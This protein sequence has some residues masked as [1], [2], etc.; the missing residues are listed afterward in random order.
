MW[1]SSEWPPPVL[2]CMSSSGARRG[3]RGTLA[4]TR[5]RRHNTTRG[6]TPHEHVTPQHVTQSVRAFLQHTNNAARTARTHTLTAP[7]NMSVMSNYGGTLTHANGSAGGNTAG[8]GAQ[9]KR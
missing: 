8:R 5:H 2:I 1:G 6:G 7:P 4:A 3:R 9:V